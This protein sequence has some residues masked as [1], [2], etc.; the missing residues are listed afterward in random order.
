MSRNDVKCRRRGEVPVVGNG[1]VEFT[2]MNLSD[3]SQNE[4]M[5][6][7]GKRKMR[8]RLAV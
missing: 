2:C 6:V 4:M 7:C 5:M 3:C 1:V 8:Y